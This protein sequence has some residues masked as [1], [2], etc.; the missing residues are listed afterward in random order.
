M[1]AKLL[2]TEE[3]KK[4]KVD[5]S[6]WEFKESH[7]KRTWVFRDFVEAFGFITRVA[8]LSESMNHH[9]ELINVYSTVSIELK[10]HDLGGLSNLDI[11]LAKAINKLE[12]N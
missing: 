10:T 2:T 5:L 9:P 7:I 3:V 6:D 11:Q 4:L 1:K 12:S 8:M